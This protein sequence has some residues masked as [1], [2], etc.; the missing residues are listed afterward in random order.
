MKLHWKEAK[1]DVRS[2]FGSQMTETIWTQMS[3][4]IGPVTIDQNKLEHLFETRTVDMKSKVSCVCLSL[5]HFVTCETY[6]NDK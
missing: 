1:P 2:V 5:S 6:L 3:R 4:E